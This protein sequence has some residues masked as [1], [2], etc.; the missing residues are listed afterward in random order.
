MI[1]QTI[2]TPE[3]SAMC[4]HYEKLHYSPHGTVVV[5]ERLAPG[6]RWAKIHPHHP[7]AALLGPYEGKQ[8]IFITVNEFRHWRMIRNLK[9]LRACYV[10]VDGFTDWEIA[11]D[12][13][14]E[15]GIPNPSFMVMSGRGIHFYWIL[16]PLPAQALPVWQRVQD[17]LVNALA[18]IG[19]DYRAKDCTRLL[20]LAGTV[21]S[22]NGAEVRGYALNN[23][24][25]TLHELADEVLG[26]RIKPAKIFDLKAQNT[27]RRRKMAAPGK[28][29]IYAWWHLVYRDLC[30]IADHYWLGGVPEGQRDTV[31]FLM[32]NALSWFANTQALENEIIQTAKTFTPSLTQRQIQTYTK[33]I[34]KRAQAASE[35]KKYHWEGK[36]V[37]PRYA[38]RAETLREWLGGDKLIVPELWPN[39]R[40]LAPREV[41]RERKRERDK[42]REENGRIRDRVAEGRYQ[43]KREEFV[44]AATDRREEALKLREKGL[45]WKEIGERMGITTNAA[46]L[47][48][49]RA[50]RRTDRP[51]GEPKD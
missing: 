50:N 19:S 33:P 18:G 51:T 10:D 9:S 8:D 5:W 45:R 41:I 11:L 28:G 27:R 49:S 22:R 46:K 43:Q 30:A 15:A 37:D 17:T 16:A 36:E 38:F 12:A 4:G 48:G 20:R 21:N 3:Y 25:W 2:E 6:R 23:D 14:R 29:S 39:L 7:V 47:L 34:L 26:P 35:G 13:I 32:A 24:I 42:V 40:A 31:L 1:A 44:T